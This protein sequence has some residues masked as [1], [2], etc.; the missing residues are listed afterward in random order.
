MQRKNI[1]KPP[2]IDIHV[3]TTHEPSQIDSNLPTTQNMSKMTIA[4][5]SGNDTTLRRVPN[6]WDDV[7]VS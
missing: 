4:H 7:K 1:Y 6:V 2:D 5:M 3:S